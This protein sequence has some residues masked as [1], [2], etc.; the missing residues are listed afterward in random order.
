MLVL[1]LSLP[2][3]DARAGQLTLNATLLESDLDQLPAVAPYVG[4]LAR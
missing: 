2:V 3:Y 4:E 1:A